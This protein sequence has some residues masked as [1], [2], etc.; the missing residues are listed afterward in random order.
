[1]THVDTCLGIGLSLTRVPRTGA[2]RQ[3][4]PILDYVS[5]KAYIKE[6]VRNSVDNELFTNWL[7]LYF[8]Q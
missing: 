7:P 1:L 6:G 8:G 3:A 2:I 5:I 4:S